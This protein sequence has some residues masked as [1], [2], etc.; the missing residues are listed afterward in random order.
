[1]NTETNV[2]IEDK[3]ACISHNAN[4]LY[5]GLRLTGLFNMNL[6]SNL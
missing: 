6:N 2:Q 4:T 1:M 5:K 3:A